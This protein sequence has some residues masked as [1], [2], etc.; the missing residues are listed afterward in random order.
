[1]LCL[2]VSLISFAQVGIGTETPQATSAMDIT[3]TTKGFLMPRMTTVQREAIIPSQ[4]AKGLQ[5]YDTTE[6]SI[7]I[8]DGVVWKDTKN[9]FVDGTDPLNAVFVD[10]NVGIGTSTPTANLEVL[11][12][13]RTS[14]DSG[15]ETGHIEMKSASGTRSGSLYFYDAVGDAGTTATESAWIGWTSLGYLYYNTNGDR[16]HYF[17]GGNVEINKDLK[18]NGTFKPGDNGGTS[19][20]LLQSTGPATTP[21]WVDSAATTAK[22]VDGTDP[23][24]AVFVNGNVGIGT[25]TPMS[26]LSLGS[27]SG[28]YGTASAKK[29]A[30][31]SDAT[32]NNFYGLGVSSGNG[33]DSSLEFHAGAYISQDDSP[34]MVLTVSKN[35]GIGTGTP[36]EKLEVIGTI[37]ASSS[38][39]STTSG[40]VEL[41]SNNTNNSGWVDFY[42]WDGAAFDRAGYIGY[43]ND[44][45]I[46]YNTYDLR[47]HYFSG[48]NVGIGT[49]NPNEALEVR[50]AVKASKGAGNTFGH[51]E[52]RSSGNQSNSGS[53]YFHD[54][55][56]SGGSVESAYIGYTDASDLYYVTHDN[57]NHS[58]TGGNI[59]TDSN[60]IANGV[61]L[62]SD[63]RL[64][65]NINSLDSGLE[66]LLKIQTKTYH[67]KDESKPT[68]L[69]IGVIAQQLETVFPELVDNSQEYKSV[70]YMGLIPVMIEAIRDLDTENKA[71][72]A[73]NTE[74]KAM[75]KKLAKR[76]SALE[77]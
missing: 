30:I 41:T 68:N 43:A 74:L 6:N 54:A 28:T 14:V 66:D 5:V 64:K 12:T 46:Q 48:G 20:Q 21:I 76:V 49:Q 58:F 44:N 42:N 35:V 10:G 7:W 38:A 36:S 11:G 33:F 2:S 55:F 34:G 71:L 50:G 45:H 24:N 27:D 15:N 4:N 63:K 56:S 25:T 31:Y 9:K 40:Y 57:R 37:R 59:I 65:K 77:K 47:N 70:N 53:I 73:E 18:L 22:F 29:L 75:M 23:S 19:G 26:R 67:W 8:S 69:Q 17:D 32:G 1:M 51:I 39:T 62:T 16:V 3:S 52:M 13:I 60:V 72:E 61:T